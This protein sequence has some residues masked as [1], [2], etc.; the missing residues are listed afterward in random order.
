VKKPV[1]RVKAKQK[2]STSTK[3]KEPE[4]RIIHE[5]KV[6]SE[7]LSDYVFTFELI[8]QYPTTRS[9]LLKKSLKKSFS[10]SFSDLFGFKQKS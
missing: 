3:N 5:E 9:Y 4:E 10:D 2:K 8:R 1:R 7:I 6:H